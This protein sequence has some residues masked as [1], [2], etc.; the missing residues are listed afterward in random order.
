M[1][2]PL[3][4]TVLAAAVAASTIAY[5]PTAD[6]N[7]AAAWWIAGGIAAGALV[8]AALA[9]PSWRG[10]GPAYAGTAPL[11][12]PNYVGTAPLYAPNY[13]APSPDYVGTAP[14][15]R[16]GVVTVRAWSP[17]WFQYCQARYRS[18][19]P[20]TGTFVGTDGRLHFCGR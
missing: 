16:P 2:H 19:N 14:L 1:I 17:G 18:F 3:K 9:Y 11:Y 20:R 5:T 8:V 12:A 10:Y 7:P 6:A 15:Y 4:T 13:V